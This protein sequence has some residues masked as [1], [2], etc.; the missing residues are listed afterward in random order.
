MFAQFTIFLFAVL[1]PLHQ[2]R[3]Q[4]K[5]EEFLH[6]LLLLLHTTSHV[7]CMYTVQDHHCRLDR[8]TE[9]WDVIDPRM[10]SHSLLC[11][12]WATAASAAFCYYYY[13]YY[14]SFCLLS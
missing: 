3:T 11:C 6:W 13:Y 4:K 1:E 7:S 8:R 9:S 10:Y 2:A 12:D 14:F 5:Q